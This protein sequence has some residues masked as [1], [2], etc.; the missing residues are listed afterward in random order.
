M[1]GT[2]TTSK[3]ANKFY[4]LCTMSGCR[5]QLHPDARL[6][7]RPRFA[8]VKRLV[9]SASAYLALQGL[10]SMTSYLAA[11][12]DNWWV[13]LELRPDANSHQWTFLTGASA[14]QSIPLRRP[15]SSRV[16]LLTKSLQIT[17]AISHDLSPEWLHQPR[18][19]DHQTGDNINVEHSALPQD[20]KWRSC[21]CQMLLSAADKAK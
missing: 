18:N 20:H 17:D 6:L 9:A 21:A 15:C 16:V 8:F 14:R 3:D 12:V 2:G 19:A 11:F 4:L 7:N 1:V 13:P 5:V 10:T